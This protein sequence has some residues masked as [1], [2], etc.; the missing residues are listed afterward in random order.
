MHQ[1]AGGV[2]PARQGSVEELR[3]AELRL[4][5]M[6]ERTQRTLTLLTALPGA[7]RAAASPP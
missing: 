6:L 2:E 4:R 7:A 1:V 3:E 5:M